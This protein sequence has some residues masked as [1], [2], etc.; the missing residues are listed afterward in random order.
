MQIPFHI[1]LFTL[2]STTDSTSISHV[3]SK[4][5]ARFETI[6][7]VRRIPT[8]IYASCLVEK[9]AEQNQVMVTLKPLNLHLLD[10]GPSSSSR[11]GNEK[12]DDI[13]RMEWLREWRSLRANPNGISNGNA[14]VRD[15][16]RWKKSELGFVKCNVDVAVWEVEGLLGTGAVVRDDQ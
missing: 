1:Q 12:I 2:T 5:G 3:G 14:C 8:G 4:G 7:S 16:V 10:Q 11:P 9:E 13:L 6:H 15:S